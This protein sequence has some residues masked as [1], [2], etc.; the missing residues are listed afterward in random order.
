MSTQTFAVFKNGARQVLGAS[1]STL[2]DGEW[3]WVANVVYYRSNAG[4]PDRKKELD[5]QMEK[6]GRERYEH[7]AEVRVSF[8]KTC[9]ITWEKLFPADR[10]L[11]LP[12]LRP[13]ADGMPPR[14]DAKIRA[15]TFDAD[16][17][18]A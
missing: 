5:E 2:N 17:H 14:C 7:S 1:N 18:D 15:E 13:P 4:N 6:M 8:E 12:F 3:F 9:G 11:L 10:R 16:A